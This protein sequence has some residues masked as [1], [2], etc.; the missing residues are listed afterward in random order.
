MK[1]Q[2]VENK[3]GESSPPEL[4]FV[5]EV[6]YANAIDI[7]I[8]SSAANAAELK[9]STQALAEQFE[10]LNR[11]R[12]QLKMMKTEASLQKGNNQN[13]PKDDSQE[14]TKKE[15]VRQIAK[16]EAAVDTLSKA[17]LPNAPGITGAVKSVSNSGV[18]LTQV[19]PRPLAFGY[20]AIGLKPEEYQ[21]MH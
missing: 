8:A 21:R 10:Q 20:R 18:T 6:Y 1:V 5:S 7:S 13:Q 3:K 4:M 11:L 16:K 17:I 9:I 12:D 2:T 14:E 15:L 19:F